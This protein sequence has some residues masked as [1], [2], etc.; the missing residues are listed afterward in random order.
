[1]EDAIARAPQPVMTKASIDVPSDAADVEA[2]LA[3]IKAMMDAPLL[4]LFSLYLEAMSKERAH[5]G[6]CCTFS[7]QDGRVMSADF[8]RRSHWRRTKQTT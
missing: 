1:M 8:G 6:L 7:M 5:G 4:V 3:R 2:S